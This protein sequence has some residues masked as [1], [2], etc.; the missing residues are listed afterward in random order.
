MIVDGVMI[1]CIGPCKQ[2]LEFLVV[3]ATQM[4]G[5]KIFLQYQLSVAPKLWQLCFVETAWYDLNLHI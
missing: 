2:Q 3:K 4:E 1:H 5:T